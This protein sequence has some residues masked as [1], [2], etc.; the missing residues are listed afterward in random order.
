[1]NIIGLVGMGLTVKWM[2][3]NKDTLPASV[4]WVS[5]LMLPLDDSNKDPGDLPK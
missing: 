3:A 5:D 4:R 1:M 2:W